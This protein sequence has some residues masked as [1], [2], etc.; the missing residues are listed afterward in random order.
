MNWSLGS[1]KNQTAF[2][3]QLVDFDTSQRL[4]FGKLTWRSGQSLFQKV[5][6][7]GSMFNSYLS[8]T[9]G[10]LPKGFW[11]LTSAWKPAQ[12]VSSHH[13]CRNTVSR[14]LPRNRTRNRSPCFDWWPTEGELEPM[15]GRWE[16]DV[17]P[18]RVPCEA[19]CDR[20]GMFR[21]GW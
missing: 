6:H 9:G 11:H 18:P 12:G 10:Y 1:Q 4:P 7:Q 15:G 5:N 8:I 14:S 19:L 20:H 2:A 3:V 16:N 13:G 17:A 21:N